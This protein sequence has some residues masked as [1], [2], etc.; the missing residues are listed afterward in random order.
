MGEADVL[1][2]DVPRRV[3]GAGLGSASG[4]GLVALAAT[5]AAAPAAAASSAATGGGRV[6]L[7]ASATSSTFLKESLFDL[8]RAD[9]VLVDLGN[10][11]AE[12]ELLACRMR[13]WRPLRR[14]DWYFA[15]KEWPGSSQGLIMNRACA[16]TCM[17]SI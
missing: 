3:T 13:I 11:F 14:R 4:C 7:L 10:K 16:R 2:L 15:A 5:L 8:D 6:L 9:E 17:V 12:V 1:L